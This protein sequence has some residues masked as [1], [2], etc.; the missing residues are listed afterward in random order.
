[1]PI[2]DAREITK[3]YPPSGRGV[4]LG[5]GGIASWF[6]PKT[7]PRQALAP[8]TLAIEAG[9]SVGIIGRNGSGKSTLLKLI[10]GVSSPTSGTL[11][12]H[13]RVASLLELGAGFHPM[14]TGRENIYLNAGLLGMRHAQTDACFDAIVD[15]AE[16]GEYIDQTV[17]TYSSGMYVR[18][19][20]S[21]AIHTNPDIF[22][23]DEVLSVGD[24]G[25]QRK[26]RARI[27]ELKDAG[28]TI[29]F[30]SHDLG[31]VNTLCD[32]VIL[33]DHG[34]VLSR[35]S[36]QATIDFYLR[37]IG[38]ASAVHRLISGKTE[39]VFNHGRLSIFHEQ[40]EITAPA[41]IK[42]QF[43]SMGQYHESTAAEW[44]LTKT[45]DTELEA[46]GVLPRLPVSIFL[47][48]RIEADT[49]MIEATWENHRSIDLSYAALQCFLPTS[50][51]RWQFGAQVGMFPE[52]GFNDRQWS[53]VV[54]ATHEPGDCYLLEDAE[55][56]SCLRIASEGNTVPLQLDNTDYM[57]QARLAHVTEAFP[58]SACPID[59]G[60]RTLASLVIDCGRT[61]ESAEA[62]R[63]EA[64]AARTIAFTGGRVRMDSGA[65]V[66]DGDKGPL[67]N[68]LHL[69]VQLKASGMW[70]MSQSLQWKAAHRDSARVVSTGRSPRLPFVLAWTISPLETGFTIAVTLDADAVVGLDEFNL[71]LSLSDTFTIWK[72]EAEQGRFESTA[73][74][75]GWRH[76]N[77]RYAPGTWIQAAGEGS[78][79][80][81]L[82][83]DAP[84]GTLHPTAILA[85]GAAS[86]P[87]LQLLCSPGQSGHFNL[88][89]GR[90]DLFSGRLIVGMDS[91]K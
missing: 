15:F 54:P 85:G 61:G 52:I 51:V 7:P 90:H 37:Q 79:T 83:A 24:E 63:Q 64:L 18:L 44:R 30:V 74:P 9:E 47:R 56:P 8:M 86:G 42:I 69:H 65:I 81:A 62:A 76:L 11:A 68:N 16:L 6:A 28:K 31:I 45:T 77:A 50:I 20:F 57:A 36:A 12:V 72:T 53:N 5:R 55:S 82:H 34:Q 40:R 49:V 38:H 80:I 66:V 23:V 22:L 84:L 10:A 29:L 67:S 26:C 32:R 27:L 48:L 75:E 4:L 58:S 39:A 73:N 19:A 87:V 88:E 46:E 13:G 78:P 71:S 17:D 41:G 91:V 2:I 60:R 33:L 21:V 70:I 1:M 25:F 43:F 89:A 3:T 59:Q 14:L 35:G